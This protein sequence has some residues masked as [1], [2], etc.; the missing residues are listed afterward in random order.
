MA[1]HDRDSETGE[2]RFL[3]RLVG[4]EFHFDSRRKAVLAEQ[5]QREPPRSR[6]LFAHQERLFSEPRERHVA[7][8]RER[9]IVAGQHDQRIRQQLLGDDVVHVRRVREEI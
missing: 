1:R 5:S 6:S 3:D 7:Y 9:V 8:V 4:T 2:Y